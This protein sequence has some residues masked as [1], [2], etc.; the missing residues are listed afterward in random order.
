MSVNSALS[1]GRSA[2]AANQAALE[3]AGNNL[4]NAANTGYTRQSASLASAGSVEIKP[5][6]FIGAGV[7]LQAVA[8]QV[9]EALNA[10]L[11]AAVGDQRSAETRS[12][13]L[14]QIETIHNALGETGLANRLDNFFNAF[15]E[16]ANNPTDAAL[17][18]L[19]V[20]QAVSV[21]G[22]VQG[23]R[24]DLTNARVQLDDRLQGQVD[25]VNSKLEQI[26]VLN[27]EIAAAEAGRGNANGLRDE[28]DRLLAEV[29]ERLD[30]STNVLDSGMMNVHLGG[31]SLVAGDQVRQ[32]DVEFT[33]GD[34]GSALA[35]RLR[36]DDGTF[37]NPASGTIGQLVAARENDLLPAVDALDEFAGAMIFQVNRVVSQG[38]GEAFFDAATADYA[39]DDPTLSLTN[40]DA[41]LDFTPSHGS[42][43]IHVTQRSTGQR[44]TTRV[45]VDLDGL[46]GPDMT[47]ND[48][49]AQLDAVDRVNASV[50]AAGRLRIASDSA[51]YRFSFSDDSSGALA[52][53][54]IN[55]LFAG[56]N[57][58]DIAVNQ[59][60][61]D[62]PK[63]LATTANHVAGGNATALAV[64]G[65]RDKALDDLGGQSLTEM[66]S[67]HVEDYAVRAER[68]SLD[69]DSASTIVDSLQNQRDAVSAVS[70]DEE[71][72]D[73]LAFQRAYQG[74]AR[75]ITVVDEMM[76]T[77][78]AMAR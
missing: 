5:N 19:A 22:Y 46:G 59:R 27:A 76:Q 74:A 35:A 44:Q 2:L 34:D 11:R 69:A 54:G 30:V 56:H 4:A 6:T 43:D 17:R 16:L 63:L 40:A 3:V 47:L 45:Q 33:A 61:A 78:L 38:Q 9:D 77:I 68:A 26:G 21:A 18:R 57:A 39:V 53:L 37:L 62:D 14:S 28:R 24:G 20:E 64:A 8:R 75:F 23:V 1:I 55:T 51:E 41:G 60:V 25:Q 70:I 65:L 73:L 10:R 67:A 32:L 15:S 66:W 49:A 13:L 48:L 36:L 72:I 71:S 29:S 12:D 50:D 31:I 52:A 7:K 42:F 58:S